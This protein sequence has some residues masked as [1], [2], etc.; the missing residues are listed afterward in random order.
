MMPSTKVYL[1]DAD[2]TDGTPEIA[3]GYSSWLD[4]EVVPGGL[5]AGP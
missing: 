4:I 5:P 2:S 3:L 1:A